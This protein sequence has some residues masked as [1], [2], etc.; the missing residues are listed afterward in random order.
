MPICK[1]IAY[2]VSLIS[3]V[4]IITLIPAFEIKIKKFKKKIRLCIFQLRISPQVLEDP[5][6][7]QYQE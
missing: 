6:M 7:Q 5:T 1:A 3:P 4:I 2:A